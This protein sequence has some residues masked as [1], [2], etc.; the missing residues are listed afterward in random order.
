M[1]GRKRGLLTHC[2]GL[3]E[4]IPSGKSGRKI[5]EEIRFSVH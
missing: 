2:E 1:R 4:G 3:E 5:V